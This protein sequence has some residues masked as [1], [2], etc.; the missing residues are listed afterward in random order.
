MKK[1]KENKIKKFIYNPWII[2][3]AFYILG[4][5]TPKTVATVKEFSFIKKE[6]TH[7]DVVGIMNMYNSPNKNSDIFYFIFFMT[8]LVI[9]SIMLIY[10]F[11][12]DYE[13]ED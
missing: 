11:T 7:I 10:Y 13:D 2:G 4:F 8:V 6:T 1:E 5:L 3:A 9:L 12:E